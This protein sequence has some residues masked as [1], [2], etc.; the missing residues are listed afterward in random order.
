MARRTRERSRPQASAIEEEPACPAE[1][2]SLSTPWPIECRWAAPII[3]RK[4]RTAA[5]WLGRLCSWSECTPSL[6]RDRLDLQAPAAG[7]ARPARAV[8]VD[9]GSVLN[10]PL[11][12]ALRLAGP[13]QVRGRLRVRRAL[14]PVTVSQSAE[15]RG[16]DCNLERPGGLSVMAA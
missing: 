10:G 2:E 11:A 7:G 13:S 4:S 15:I 14:N 12:L 3:A 8:T 1:S 6:R 9:S 16:H 5:H